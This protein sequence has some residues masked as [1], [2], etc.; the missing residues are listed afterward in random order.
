MKKKTTQ[1]EN[2]IDLYSMFMKIEE[3][4]KKNAKQHKI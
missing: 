2:S 1:N 3:E 4:T